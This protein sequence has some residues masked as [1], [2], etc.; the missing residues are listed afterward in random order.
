MIVPIQIE[1]ARAVKLLIYK[2][3]N[4]SYA[5][6][7]KETKRLFDPIWKTPEAPNFSSFELPDQ[8]QLYKLAGTFL[9]NFGKSKNLANY[10]E[11]GKDVLTKAI[12]YF[13]QLDEIEEAMECQMMLAIGYSQEG[14]LDEYEALLEDAES[15]FKNN[16]RHSVYLLIQINYLIIEIARHKIPQALAR[17]NR[18]AV[19]AEASDDLRVKTLYLTQTGIVHQLAGDLESSLKCLNS[20]VFFAKAIENVQ[21]EAMI[22]NCLANTYRLL[23]KYDDALTAIGHALRLAREDEGWMANFLDTEANIHLD[24]NDLEKATEIAATAVRYF[25]SGEDFGGLTEAMW[26]QMK[27]HFRLDLREMAFKI[28]FE[29][30]TISMQQ[31]GSKKA[32]QYLND[33]LDMVYVDNDTFFNERIILYKRFLVQNAL[34]RTNGKIVEAAKILGIKKHQTLSAMIRKH[35]PE[36]LEDYQV[37]RKTRS[38]RIEK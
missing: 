10:Q 22:T 31:S 23:K 18:I 37:E 3:G 32:D 33:F 15:Y 6:N 38:D 11:R 17:I 30:Y 25:R 35:F 13:W 34:Y 8:A 27:I 12:D 16:K 29:I 19:F 14:S 9:V 1:T 24:R 28:F 5:R 2:I 7:Y 21:Y 4:A 36:V 20:A 26:T